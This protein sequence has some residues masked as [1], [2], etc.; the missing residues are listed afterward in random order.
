MDCER[1]PVSIFKASIFNAGSEVGGSGMLVL[2]QCCASNER[3][4]SMG[5]KMLCVLADAGR[6]FG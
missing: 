6:G 1:V 4:S 3:L 2:P 5:V